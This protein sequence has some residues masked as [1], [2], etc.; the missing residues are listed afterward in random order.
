MQLAWIDLL[1]QI[2]L[3]GGGFLIFCLGGFWKK[4]PQGL[5]FGVALAVAIGSG[6]A[7]LLLNPQEPLFLNMF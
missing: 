7:A 1:P 6:A 4:R 2:L 3:A 5:L